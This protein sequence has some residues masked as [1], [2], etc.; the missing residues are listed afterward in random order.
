MHRNP[1]FQLREIKPQ[2]LL[3]KIPVGVEAPAGGT[4]SLTGEFIGETHRIVEYTQNH[5]PGNQHQNGPI[6]LWVA[7]EVIEGR[8]RAK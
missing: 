3:L 4:P 6:C 8:G 5:P 1:G 7:G 2:T